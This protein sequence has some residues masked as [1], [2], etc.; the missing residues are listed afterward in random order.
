[1]SHVRGRVKPKQS[2]GMNEKTSDAGEMDVQVIV[3]Y[4]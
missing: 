4:E 2:I 1:M 3:E